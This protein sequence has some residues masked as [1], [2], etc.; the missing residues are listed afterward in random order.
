M[1]E[2]S[3]TRWTSPCWAGGPGRLLGRLSGCAE[4]GPLV[5]EHVVIEARPGALGGGLPLS[6]AAKSPARRS[7]HV[8]RSLS[9]AEA[10]EG[11]R[12]GLRR[13]AR[14]SLRSR[15]G[16]GSRSGWWASSRA[17]SL[18]SVGEGQGRR[19]HRGA[20][21]SSRTRATLRIEGSGEGRSRKVRFK[22]AIR[23]HRLRG[24][25]PCPGP[26]AAERADSMDS[27]APALRACRTIPD[28]LPR[29]SAAGTS[30][31]SSS[32]L[33]STSTLGKPAVTLVE[34]D[35]RPACPAWTVDLVQPLQ[36]RVGTTKLLH[37][38]SPREP[39]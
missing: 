10:G 39:D 4:L 25:A 31:P 2:S 14:I 8:A 35:R 30:V 26:H 38:H 16:S 12:G 19:G 20:R 32:A 27:T 33:G 21:A 1:G 9:E 34:I 13:A 11:V 29:E 37:R 18:A 6:R 28:R 22:H 17:G 36:R 23:G 15:C 5:E 7:C 24:R 3:W